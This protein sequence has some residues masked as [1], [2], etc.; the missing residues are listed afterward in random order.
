MP[1]WLQT[2]LPFIALC[3]SAIALIGVPVSRFFLSKT[4]ATHEDLKPLFNRLSNVERDIA[5]VQNDIEHLPQ[6][7]DFDRLNAGVSSVQADVA[8]LRAQGAS[9]VATLGRIS[10]HLLKQ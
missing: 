5:L 6:R 3:V 9:T 7:A 4:V 2:W 8:A 1:V 10:D